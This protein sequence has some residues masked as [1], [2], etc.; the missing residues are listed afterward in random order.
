MFKR[1]VFLLASIFAASV[2]A[3]IPYCAGTQVQGSKHQALQNVVKE[4]AR[5]NRCVIG[6]NCLLNY[7]GAKYHISWAKDCKR[8]AGQGNDPK[9]SSFICSEGVCTP[10]GYFLPEDFYDEKS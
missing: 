9:G 1:T 5:M 7:D 3:D 4:F 6:S 8:S 10:Y 2:Y